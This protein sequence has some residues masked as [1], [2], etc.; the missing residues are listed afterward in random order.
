M[1]YIGENLKEEV[2][3]KA[4]GMGNVA[5]VGMFTPGWDWL[6]K[7]EIGDEIDCCDE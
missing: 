7:L 4:K 1:N 6:T 5:P 2:N 3:F